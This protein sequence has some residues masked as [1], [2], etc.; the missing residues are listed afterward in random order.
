MKILGL[1]LVLFIMFEPNGI[2]G[3]WLKLKAYFLNFPLYK[4]STFK[5]QKAY[6]RTERLR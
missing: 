1:I 6:T 3:R 4:A 5:R 2:Y